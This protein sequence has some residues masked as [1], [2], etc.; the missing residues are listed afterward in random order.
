M[1]ALFKK[2]VRYYLNNPIG[3][4]VLI[5]FGVS[6]NFLYMKD[7]FVIGSVS[8]PSFFGLFPWIFLIFIPALAMRAFSEEKRLNTIELLLTLPIS[9]TQIVFAK[10]FTY[11]FL[12]KIGLLLTLTIPVSFFFLTHIYLPEVLINYIGCVFMASS[13]IAVTMF[14][15][16]LTKNQI[17]SFLFSIITLFL[18]LGISSE[19]LSSILPKF[20]Q[21]IL[22]YLGPIYHFQNFMKGILDIRSIYYFLSITGIFLYLTILQF[23]RKQ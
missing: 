15:S 22:I 5:L 4:I 7:V 10:F 8:L 1:L 14:F 2:E 11:I 3:Y 23:K 20:V 17:V 19:L 18:M 16:S 21:D 9:E 13:F 12:V 6:I